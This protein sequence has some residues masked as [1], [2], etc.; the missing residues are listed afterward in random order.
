MHYHEVVITA[1]PEFREAIAAELMRIGS[2]GLVEEE[3]RLIAYF[4]GS[5]PASELASSLSIMQQ[6]LRS[7]DR[8]IAVSFST[9]T[10]E[11][12]DWNESWKRSFVPLA[13]GE[14]FA[15]LPPWE[16]PLPGRIPLII[17]PGMAFGTG[18]H[19]TT[20][21]CIILMEKYAVQ[22]ARERFLD[23]GTGTGLLAIAALRLGFRDVEGVDT[24]PLAIDAARQNIVRNDAASIRL[25][26]G[27]LEA[28]A[29][30]YDMI[31][32]NLISGTLIVLAEGIA[33]KLRHGGIAVL[34]GIL[35]GQDDEVVEA[36]ERSGLVCRDRLADGKWISLAC[37]R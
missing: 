12:K 7:S 18:H 21:S 1:H 35:G 2:L 33:E 25:F 16:S 14:R 8:H 28:A 19:E 4:P 29:G 5:V 37:S 10:I 24:D 20:R 31:A 32:A 6:L 30:P 23:L 15:I 22:V 36:M 3:Q 17:D 26:A 27:G 13:V 9:G 34:S 11:D